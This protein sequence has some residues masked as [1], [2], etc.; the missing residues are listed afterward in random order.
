MAFLTKVISGDTL[1]ISRLHD[2][3]GNFAGW[4]NVALHAAPA[5]VT[6][7][8][9]FCFG[10]N[11]ELPWISYSAIKLLTR[12]LHKKSRVLE[13]GSGM[14]TIW[15]AGR[16][17]EVFSVEDCPPWYEKV[18][19]IIRKKGLDNIT[20][21][22]AESDSEYYTFMSQDTIGFDLIMVDG[23][24]RSKCIAHAEK[25]LK[26]GGILYLDNSDK[27]SAGKGGDMRVAE[28]LSRSFAKASNAQIRTFTDFAP[29]QF[30]VEQCMIVKLP[31]SHG[32]F[33]KT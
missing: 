20:Y 18:T 30:F 5:V 11:P 26:P 1:R 10:Y 19:K 33:R 14:S 21:R 23:S 28:E 2:E 32:A 29:T 25:L 27:D 16:A 8:F 7:F 3:K 31:G 9:H 12:F 22:L 17:G 6:G 13:F 24:H 4:K 15:Y